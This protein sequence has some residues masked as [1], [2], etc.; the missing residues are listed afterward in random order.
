MLLLRGVFAAGVIAEGRFYIAE[1]GDVTTA[2]LIGLLALAAGGLLLVGFMTP[3]VAAII[4]AGAAAIGLSL[5]PHCSPSF[6]DT[7]NSVILAAAIVVAIA[8]LGPGAFS[9]D[10]RVFGRREI[11]I[12]PDCD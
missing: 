10:A 2:W 9:I 8:G 4:A 7:R 11:I 6:F 1:G 5:L 12:P 3:I